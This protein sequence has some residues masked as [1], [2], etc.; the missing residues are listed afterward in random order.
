MNFQ[1]PKIDEGTQR[2]SNLKDGCPSKM[3]RTGF[4]FASYM[5]LKDSNRESLKSASGTK[6]RNAKGLT[7]EDS[8]FTSH[9][10]R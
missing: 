1:D 6:V 5:R 10:I 7:V 9:S 3:V 4:S 8:E 2:R